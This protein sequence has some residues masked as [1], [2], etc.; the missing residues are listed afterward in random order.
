MEIAVFGSLADITGGIT[1][2]FA[3]AINTDQ[4][5]KALLL[6]FPSLGDIPFAIVVD[7][8]IIGEN[9]ELNP[10]DSV[11]LLPPYSGG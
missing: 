4:L 5:K 8:E 6:R 1:L 7:D 11:A 2:Q 9:T 3:P 10:D